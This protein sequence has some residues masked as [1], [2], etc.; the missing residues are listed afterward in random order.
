MKKRI[1]IAILACVLVLSSVLAGCGSSGASQ[2]ASQSS[3]SSAVTGPKIFN[4]TT[5]AAAT[6]MNA[7][8]TEK[9]DVEI[10]D[11][12]QA[13]LYQWMPGADRKTT[14]LDVDLALEKPTASTDG[15]T[16]TIKIN[17]K[18]KWA[19]G[20]PINADTFIYSWKMA[21]DP[22]MLNTPG[23]T[24]CGT[25]Y[26]KVENAMAYYTQVSTGKPVDWANVGFKKVDDYTLS[27]KTE[28]KFT[29]QE[30]M[31]HFAWR[32]TGPVYQKLYEAGLD[33]SKLTTTYGTD[34]DKYIASGPFSIKTWVK[35]ADIVLEKNA[36]YLHADQVKLSGINVR[37]AA[38]DGTKQQLF[39]KGD[40]DYML[41]STGTLSKYSDDPRVISYDTQ[42]IRCIEI[43]RTNPDKPI[44]HNKN[45]LQALYYAVDRDAMAKLVYGIP[46]PLIISTRSMALDNGTKYRDLPV[47]KA[48]IPEKNGYN[49]TLAK[50]LF[51]KALAEEKLTKLTLQLNYF[52]TIEA[53]KVLSEY[54]QKSLAQI[55]GAD[56][57]EL[58]L[59]SSSTALQIMQA[60]I[61]SNPASYELS[62][63]GWGLSA[64]A[65][66]PAAKF[67]VYL[68]NSSRRVANY[69]NKE[70]DALYAEAIT[71]AVRA[72]KQ[73]VA[74]LSAKMEKIFRD[75]VLN[76]P[77][78]QVQ[79]YVLLSERL[80]AP[81]NTNLPGLGWGWK[82]A[83][84]VK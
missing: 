50:E 55:F 61:T 54:M 65:Y 66:S 49:P 41:L 2:S 36:N 82:F 31:Q 29:Q 11:L 27:V 37:V 60:S 78:F 46:S 35:G 40:L 13:S 56:K 76:V 14:Y 15:S 25:N 80:K 23:G 43:N 73:K 32:T 57:F 79:N 45:F 3:K 83:D 28:G 38:D 21:L 64:E 42:T 9:V 63:M 69:G 6:T 72:D 81:A 22:K 74:E 12:V 52:D 47:A 58:K 10:I 68:S 59:Q 1:P 5:N 7:H 16:W 34:K 71:D 26:I 4:W 18:A 19:N 24:T 33:A 30:V 77:V 17:P 20:D 48:N 44:L 8:T 84:I 75:E 53:T 62:W 70:I 67:Q 39:E 51:D